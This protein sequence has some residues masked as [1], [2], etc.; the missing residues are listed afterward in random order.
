MTNLRDQ[1]ELYIFLKS[2]LLPHETYLGLQLCSITQKEFAVRN[3]CCHSETDPFA[4]PQGQ[5]GLFKSESQRMRPADCHS[6]GIAYCQMFW[7]L[8]KLASLLPAC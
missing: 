1:S 5:I 7:C 6:R 2:S 8:G 3:A 4:S